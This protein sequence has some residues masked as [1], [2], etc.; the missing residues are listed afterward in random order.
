MNTLQRAHFRPLLQK[1]GDLSGHPA[2]VIVR[3]RYVGCKDED[4]EKMSFGA[5]SLR[6]NVAAAQIYI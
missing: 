6:L 5:L 4:S 3:F 2:G 1:L